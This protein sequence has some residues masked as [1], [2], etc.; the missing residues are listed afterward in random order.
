[1]QRCGSLLD[2]K[3]EQLFNP[4]NEN[5]SCINILVTC[6]GLA[7]ME[8]EHFLF[9]TQKI[10]VTLVRQYLDQEFWGEW[11]CF[12]LFHASSSCAWKA[13]PL[14]LKEEPGRVCWKSFPSSGA[15]LVRPGSPSRHP[16]PQ[17]E[18]SGAGVGRPGRAGGP[19]GYE[20]R[21][22][23]VT[24]VKLSVFQGSSSHH[25]SAGGS[26]ES[27]AFPCRSAPWEAVPAL[28]CCPRFEASGTLWVSQVS[29]SRG[30]C[31]VLLRFAVLGS[32]PLF[33]TLCE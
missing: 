29:P 15:N 11:M 20:V 6:M 10:H 13:A 21:K 30:S 16:L 26:C 27:S 5:P 32:E 4:T 9:S 2:R 22:K 28:G 8:S 12:W 25:S 24:V 23:V 7:L 3:K 14:A 1:M 31:P 33:L 17:P 18:G 19:G